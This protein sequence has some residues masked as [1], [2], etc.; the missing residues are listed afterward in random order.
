MRTAGCLGM[1]TTL[2]GLG[3]PGR[4]FFAGAQFVFVGLGETVGLGLDG[5]G[6]GIGLGLRAL[7]SAGRFISTGDEG[8]G[9]QQAGK[10]KH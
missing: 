3:F 6:A 8:G 9:G 7:D 10:D 1:G 2:A 5:T 4:A